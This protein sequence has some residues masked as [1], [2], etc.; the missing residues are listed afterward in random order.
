MMGIVNCIKELHRDFAAANHGISNLITF[1]EQIII[2]GRVLESKRTGPSGGA[3]GKTVVLKCRILYI[4]AAVN[5]DTDIEAIK[6][7]AVMLAIR[8]AVKVLCLQDGD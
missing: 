1:I 2:P 4:E 5:L 7:E 6:A 8:D 3:N